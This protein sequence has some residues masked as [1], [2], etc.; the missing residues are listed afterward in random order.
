MRSFLDNKQITKAFFDANLEKVRTFLLGQI[1]DEKF[2][3]IEDSVTQAELDLYFVQGYLDVSLHSILSKKLKEHEAL[4][5]KNK[6]QKEE[7]S[8]QSRKERETRLPK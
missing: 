4:S 6:A 8:K 2:G 5:V 7:I 3:K 1:G